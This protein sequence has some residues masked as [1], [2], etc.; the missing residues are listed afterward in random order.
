M[1]YKLSGRKY[2]VL[3][4]PYETGHFALVHDFSTISDGTDFS[5]S[6]SRFRLDQTYFA[7]Y[8]ALSNINLNG[9]I[10]SSS[11]FKTLFR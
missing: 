7:Q 10:A 5:N 9:A 2:Y 1:E 3:R 8:R 4:E 11:L 6:I